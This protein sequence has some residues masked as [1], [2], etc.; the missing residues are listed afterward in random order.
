MV[1]TEN[2][3]LLGG[4][5]FYGL[6]VK[7]PFVE[8][9]AHD[10]AQL[11]LLRIAVRSE[12]AVFDPQFVRLTVAAQSLPTT[13]AILDVSIH[14]ARY[15]DLVSPS[16]V[17]GLSQNVDMHQLEALVSDRYEEVSRIQLALA[18]NISAMD[19]DTLKECHEQGDLFVARLRGSDQLVGMIAVKQDAIG[20]IAGDVVQEEVVAAVYAGNGF[21]TE[22]QCALAKRRAEQHPNRLMLGTIDRHNHASRKSAE[23]AGR[24]EVLRRVFLPL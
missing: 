6:D 11:D 9:V 18:K 2:G 15:C 24:P 23:R 19:M 14:A 13:D 20:W 5:R 4:I 21:A 17:I 16:D 8:V 3:A 12:W 22:M 7:R 10:F 1:E